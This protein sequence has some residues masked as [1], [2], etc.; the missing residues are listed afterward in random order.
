[1]V[2]TV[3]IKMKVESKPADSADA[4]QTAIKSQAL[5]D[6]LN[7]LNVTVTKQAN[8]DEPETLSDTDRVLEIVIPYQTNDRSNITVYR[9]NGTSAAALTKLTERPSSGYR[10]GAYYVGDGFVVVYAKL[11]STYAIGYTVPYYG[12]DTTN[13]AELIIANAIGGSVSVNPDAGLSRQ[14]HKP[15]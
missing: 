5:G 7:Y 8:D 13:T 2:N 12:G 1:M 3:T 4:A 6:K 9:Y 15:Y 14:D 11:F 10:D